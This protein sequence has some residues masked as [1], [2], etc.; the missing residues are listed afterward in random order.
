MLKD[1]KG[2]TLVELLITVAIMSIIALAVCGFLMTGVRSYSEANSDIN[3][4]QEAQLAMN[5][6]ADVLVDA[7]GKVEYVCCN[8]SQEQTVCK[9]DELTFEPDDKL[10]LLY[11]GEE[12]G[13]QDYCFLWDK[14]SESLYYA[15]TDAKEQIPSIKEPENSGQWALLARRVTQF[16]V[17]LSQFEE[18]RVVQITMKFI[19]GDREYTTSSNVTVRNRTVP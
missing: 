13:N 12:S 15:E 1:Q 10:L 5:Q 16:A 11:Q 18:K 8:G 7:T 2:F 19:C 6:I 17:D 14:A 9:E 4:Q 3:V